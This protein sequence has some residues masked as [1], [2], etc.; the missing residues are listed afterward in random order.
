MR[1]IVIVSSGIL[2]IA[3][4]GRLFP[5]V[6]PSQFYVQIFVP[7]SM[8]NERQHARKGVNHVVPKSGL[9]PTKSRNK[10]PASTFIELAFFPQ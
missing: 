9:I 3:L 8:G 10:K 7:H 1:P 5:L 2:Y 6:R 4:Y